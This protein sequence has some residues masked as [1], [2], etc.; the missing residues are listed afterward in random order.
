MG[1]FSRSK[2]KKKKADSGPT[3]AK[4]RA[5]VRT[6]LYKAGLGD[7]DIGKLSL[8]V[9]VTTDLRTGYAQMRTLGRYTFQMEIHPNHLGAGHIR[10]HEAARV[11]IAIADQLG[12]EVGG[13][14]PEY[15]AYIKPPNGKPIPTRHFGLLDWHP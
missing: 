12:W 4:W 1:L 2:K 11:A 10:R 14:R 15:P 13:G 8:H 6:A 5:E 9:K 7:F 3:V